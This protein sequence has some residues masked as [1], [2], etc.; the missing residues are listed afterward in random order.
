MSS[1]LT[2]TAPFQAAGVRSTGL[3][4][5]QVIALGSLAAPMAP[6]GQGAIAYVTGLAG[7]DEPCFWDGA[8]N[9]RRMSDK[10]VAS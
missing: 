3:F 1:V 9:W 5:P 6:F 8:G 7:G 2:T 4:Q 10:T